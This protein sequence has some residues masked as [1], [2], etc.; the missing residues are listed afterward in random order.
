M[1]VNLADFCVRLYLDVHRIDG[2]KPLE[3]WSGFRELL[4]PLEKAALLKNLIKMT[5]PPVN[6]RCA[7]RAFMEQ[8]R[9]AGAAVSAAFSWYAEST[10]G[11]LFASF[12]DPPVR[13]PDQKRL[14]L[15][16]KE[17]IS[18]IVDRLMEEEKTAVRGGA[19]APPG[20]EQLPDGLFDLREMRVTDNELPFLIFTDKE[21]R[22]IHGLALA[23]LWLLDVDSLF[24][25]ALQGGPGTEAVAAGYRQVMRK[26]DQDNPLFAGIGKPERGV[27]SG[28]IRKRLAGEDY[29]DFYDRIHHWYEKLEKK[30]VP[31]A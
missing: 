6:E 25:D 16:V 24:L 14:Y 7:S 23:Y 3:I 27:L 12:P 28:G 9:M 8:A 22:V 2:V 10:A 19:H 4:D 13:E 1:E 15:A 31:D 18:S 30:L 17:R 26:A 20:Q 21:Y 29:L 5:I 11:R